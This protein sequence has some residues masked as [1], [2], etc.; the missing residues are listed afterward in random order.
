MLRASKSAGT[1]RYGREYVGDQTPELSG[2]APPARPA[3]TFPLW[4]MKK[5]SALFETVLHLPIASHTSRVPSVVFVLLDRVEP[6]RTLTP[7]FG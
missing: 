3:T 6:G 7:A 1:H 5:L 2:G 4:S